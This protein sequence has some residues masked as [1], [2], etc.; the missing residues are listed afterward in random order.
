[1]WGGRASPHV[2]P[3]AG[4]FSL[5]RLSIVHGRQMMDHWIDKK[6]QLGRTNFSSLGG[7]FC[8]S[9]GAKHE[10]KDSFPFTSQHF[11]IFQIRTLRC[12]FQVRELVPIQNPPP[13]P[14]SVFVCVCM[15]GARG[16]P[17]LLFLRYLWG[18]FAHLLPHQPKTYPA[19]QAGWPAG[20][21]QGSSCLCLPLQGSQA[22]TGVPGLT[23]FNLGSGRSNSG[24]HAYK[25]SPL[26]EPSSCPLALSFSSLLVP[27]S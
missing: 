15:W 24:P 13:H 4:P 22:C 11:H 5:Q 7:C 9:F 23:S 18:L 17:W 16:Q 19:G 21:I 14:F 8:S 6:R 25:A 2:V 27:P 1:M 26:P 12:L 10:N 3:L 20:E